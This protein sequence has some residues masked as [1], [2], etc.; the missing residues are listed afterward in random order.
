MKTKLFLS[1]L[2][3]ISAIGLS[4]PGYAESDIASKGHV[5]PNTSALNFDLNNQ[6]ENTLNIDAWMTDDQ[7]WAISDMNG[8]KGT[9]VNDDEHLVIESWM[10]SDELFRITPV[11]IENPKAENSLCIES[12]MTDEDLWKL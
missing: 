7:L 10:T 11:R 4:N 2:V 8:E 3:L 1:M 9:A 12:W 5:C 6:D